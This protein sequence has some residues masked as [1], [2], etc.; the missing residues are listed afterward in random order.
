MKATD[1]EKLSPDPT[2]IE[3]VHGVIDYNG[4]TLACPEVISRHR[5]NNRYSHF[6]SGVK[7][8][9][10]PSGIPMGQRQEIFVKVCKENPDQQKPPLDPAKKETVLSSLICGP[11]GLKFNVPVELRL[12]HVV[13]GANVGESGILDDVTSFV[14]KS[15]SGNSWKNI[16]LLQPPTHNPQG[17][18]SVLVNHF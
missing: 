16:E 8:I 6:K 12:P 13:V 4:G 17:Y 5:H 1:A 11:K 15:G 9:V 14:L 10:P 3:S 7:L 2:V 18:V